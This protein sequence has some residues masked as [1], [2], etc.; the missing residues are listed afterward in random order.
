M[1]EQAPVLLYDGV[2]ALCNGAVKTILRFDKVGTMR[3]AALDS[4]YGAAVAARHPELADIDSL[5]VVDDPGGPAERVHVRSDGYLRI[6]TYL[7]GPW[8]LLRVIAVLPRPVRDWCYDLVARTR[9]R[10]F[11]KYDTCPL[12]PPAVRTRFLS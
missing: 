11:G 6:L 12:P 1:N 10:I 4:D 7:G 2:C 3:F 9:Y 5:V 8:R